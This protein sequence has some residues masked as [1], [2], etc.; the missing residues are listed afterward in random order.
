MGLITRAAIQQPGRSK[1]VA[2]QAADF[3]RV[4]GR[5]DYRDGRPA[6]SIVCKRR[7]PEPL[8]SGGAALCGIENSSPGSSRGG[9]GNW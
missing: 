7:V 4:G 2:Q 9:A 5:C 1:R 8:E 3:T 6:A